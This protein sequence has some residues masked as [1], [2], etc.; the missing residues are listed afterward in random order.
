LV[1]KNKNKNEYDQPKSLQCGKIVCNSCEIIIEKNA[2]NKKFKCEIRL[3]DHII[4]D[5]GLSANDLAYHHNKLTTT[6]MERQ[7]I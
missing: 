7:K 6:N 5:E 1:S 2:V 3:R 4:P